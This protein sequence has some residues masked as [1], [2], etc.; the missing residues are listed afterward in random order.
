MTRQGAG[1]SPLFDGF[2]YNLSNWLWLLMNHENSSGASAAPQRRAS[3]AGHRGHPRR[4]G[5]Q[6][7]ILVVLELKIIMFL[8]SGRRRMGNDGG[9]E[10]VARSGKS[11]AAWSAGSHRHPRHTGHPLRRRHLL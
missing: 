2:A 6:T 11:V 1:L 8:L 5:R 9:S 7:R 4:P 10:T 3:A